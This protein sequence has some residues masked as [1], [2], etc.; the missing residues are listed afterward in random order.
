MFNLSRTASTTSII[1]LMIQYISFLLAKTIYHMLLKEYSRSICLKTGQT[2]KAIKNGVR[3][4][5]DSRS[6]LENCLERTGI[7]IFQ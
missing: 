5:G 1:P 2:K 7:H 6:T 3:M 4:L